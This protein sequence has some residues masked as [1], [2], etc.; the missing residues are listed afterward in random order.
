MISPRHDL[1][2]VTSL[3][4]PITLHPLIKTSSRWSTSGMIYDQLPVSSN[5][6]LFILSLNKQSLISLRLNLRPVASLIKPVTPYSLIKTSSHW[7]H[8]DMI[9]NHAVTSLIKPVTPYPLIKTKTV[10]DPTQT[11]STTIRLSV[12]SNQSRCIPL[13]PIDKPILELSAVSSHQ[14]KQS[15]ISS[16]H[17]LRPCS[18]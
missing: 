8:P 3:I 11:C 13:S 7:S 17:D 12:S 10:T 5:Q 18:Y 16:R 1:R 4:K 14:N 6:S 9:Y 2:P 15:L